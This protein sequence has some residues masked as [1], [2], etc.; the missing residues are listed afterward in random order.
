MTKRAWVLI[1][2]QTSSGKFDTSAEIHYN[3]KMEQN[4][5]AGWRTEFKEVGR[6]LLISLAIVIPIRIFIAQP[7]IVRGSSMEPNFRDRQYLIVDEATYYLREPKRLEVVIFRFP[8]NPR[9]FFIKRI[10]GLPGER[11]EVKR[12]EIT[13]FP[14]G[15]SEGYRLHETYLTRELGIQPDR[16]FTLGENEYLVLGDNRDFSSDSRVWGPLPRRFIVGR[17]FFTVYPPAAFGFVPH[18]YS[19]SLVPQ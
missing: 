13:V 2:H 17:A 1:I 10:I 15:S 14:A 18:T 19:D 12:K 3:P 5:S 4:Q 9:Q 7:F 16:A 6:V 8:L 11:I